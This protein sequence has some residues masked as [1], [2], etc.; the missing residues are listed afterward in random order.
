MAV[1]TDTATEFLV[2]KD[3]LRTCEFRTAPVPAQ[4]DLADGEVLAKVDTFAFTAN[5][6]TYAVFGEQMAYWNFF[7]AVEGW[8]RI[9]VWGFA[10]VVASK[11]EGVKVGE[12]LY[13]YWPLSTHLVLQPA[14]V[15]AAGFVDG[16]EHRKAL[17]PVYNNYLRTAADP[18]YDVGCEAQQSLLRPLF[19]TGFLIAD[20]IADADYYGAK[21]VLFSS[22]SSKTALCAAFC[23]HELCGAGCD[24]IG[25]TSA[26]NRKF[27]EALGCYDKTVTYDEIASLPIE[28]GGVYIDMSGNGD[29]RAAVHS[30]FADNLKFSLMVG[31]S[32]WENGGE[33]VP[34]PGAQPTFFFAP[35]QI[36]KREADWG[37][38]ALQQRLGGAWARLIGP[39]RE[40]ITVA[41]S[42]GEKSIEHVYRETLEGRVLP[43]QGN[44]LSF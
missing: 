28:Q 33:M 9:P 7:P 23:L 34:L 19:M 1:Q 22:A 12:R 18:G 44:I 24:V 20:M 14:R 17:H 29:V 15:T 39:A 16:T 5:N 42:S 35:D 43:S 8:G 2:K 25:L 32:H 21:Q 26:G 6:I 41:A 37:A 36:K 31:A 10:D 11:H 30:H 38:D 3:D 27:V 13:G 4:A 40:W